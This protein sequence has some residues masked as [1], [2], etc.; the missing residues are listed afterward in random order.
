LARTG[1]VV[2]VVVVLV[3]TAGSVVELSPTVVEVVVD[4]V[5]LVVVVFEAVSPANKNRR[6]KT[7]APTPTIARIMITRS[8]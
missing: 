7:S 8:R 3:T 6:K 2:E 1:T 4:V 5:E